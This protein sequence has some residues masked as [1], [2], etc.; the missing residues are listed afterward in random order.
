MET[1]ANFYV[2]NVPKYHELTS[3][4]G[5]DSTWVWMA[6]DCSERQP[7][8][9]WVA[10][11]LASRALSVQF[12][13][14]FAMAKRILRAADHGDS[15]VC[16]VLCLRVTLRVV[17]CVM[18]CVGVHVVSAVVSVVCVVVAV[19]VVVVVV[20]VCVCVCGVACVVWHGEKPR[21]S[22][23]NVAVCTCTTRT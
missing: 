6:F 2:L 8:A 23:Q 10:R 14:A 17:L 1:I 22:I 20:C 21:V 7:K 4:T 9:E 13:D 5:N 15:L 3:N 18:L 12:K 11:T 19:G 16:G